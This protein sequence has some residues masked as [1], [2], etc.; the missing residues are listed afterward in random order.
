[1]PREMSIRNRSA[2]GRFPNVTLGLVEDAEP[3]EEELIGKQEGDCNCRAWLRRLCCYCYREDKP[4]TG[5]SGT[6]TSST[7]S[8]GTGTNITGTGGTGTSGTGT[9][10]TGTGGM[11]SSGTVSSGTGT[12]GT[13]TGG[14]GSSGTGSG[15]MG[16][17]GTGSGGMGIGGTGS[18][19]TGDVITDIRDKLEQPETGA[20]STM[21]E[22]TLTVKSVDLMKS[23]TGQNRKEHYTNCY[24]GN[25]LIIR[26]GQIFQ[27]WIKLSRAFNT[28]TDKLHL[29]LKLGSLPQMSKNTHIIIPLVEELQDN[30]WEAKIM[31]QKGQKIR[32]SV[33]SPP[34]ALIGQYQ[35]TVA[36]QSPEGMA[37]ST[38]DPGND[39]YMLFNPW[40]EGDTVYMEDENEKKE[41]VL[42]DVG[43]L[44]FGTEYQMDSRTWNFGQFNEG[45]LQACLFLLDKSK[46][47]I[48][49]RGDAVNVVRVVS[50]MVNSIDDDGVLEGNWSGNY[51]GGTAP[52]AWTGSVEILKKYYTEKGK[53]VKFGQCWVFSAV[54]TTVLRCL[55]IPTRSVTNFNSAHDTDVSLTIDVY[56][57][58]NLKPIEE[59]NTD[60]VWNFHVWNDCWMA[61]PDLPQG[62]G[63]WQA[64][65]ATPQETSQGT[66][67]CGPAAITAVRLG[68]VYIKYDAPFVF[69]EVNSDKVY[70]Q[71]SANGTFNVVHI[72]ENVIGRC[73]LTKAVGSDESNDITLLYKFPQGS[74]EQRIA[75]E[76][77]CH[78][79]SKPQVYSAPLTKDVTLEVKVNGEGPHMG[80]DAQLTIALGNKSAEPR[81][82]TLYIQA[83]VMYYTGVLKG[84]VK[85]DSIPVQLKANEEK[86][87]NWVLKYQDYQGQLV[88]HAALMLMLS[89]RVVETK[90]ILATQYNFR[91]QTPDLSITP[92][93]DAVV[94]KEMAAK[95]VFT[96]PLQHALKNV[97][98]HVEGLGLMSMRQR[99]IGEIGS[100]ATLTLTER[101]VPREHGPKKLLA[102]L[103]CKQLTQVHGVADIDVKDPPAGAA[104]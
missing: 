44:Y 14:T 9:G 86:T 73:I 62:M 104:Q 90:Q 17:G 11:G 40:C 56:L 100:H 89:G 85:K 92:V 35:L 43:R 71:R 53:P 58:E 63:G 7:R 28:S 103:D 25:N 47:P 8:G 93:G 91:L 22:P 19:S 1:M 38:Y 34:T 26:R 45:I 87:L 4:S 16:T 54:T 2:V 12:G 81:N 80:S 20:I 101:F 30:Q 88:D 102:S 6:G 75:V 18:S 61:R 55:G 39:I 57:D 48:S 37:L 46:M 65:D 36:T 76:T 77:A 51:E 69:A 59:L 68:E 84:T 13:G 70:W 10:G 23:K 21:H 32:L 33:N 95:I 82:T 78:Y 98:V 24:Q 64:V 79:G 94:G 67:C 3:D 60:S 99:T 52:T 27:M 49:G 31:E 50:A 41:Y 29:E 72:E 97:T 42:N 66:F 74:D 15:G 83:M 5:S 96:N